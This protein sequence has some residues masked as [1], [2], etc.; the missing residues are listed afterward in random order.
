M[1]GL[2]IPLAI[3]ACEVGAEGISMAPEL[4]FGLGGCRP[5]HCEFRKGR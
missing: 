4:E 3:E 2:G 1:A 5:V